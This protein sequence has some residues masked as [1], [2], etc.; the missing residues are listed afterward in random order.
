MC[1][2]RETVDVTEVRAGIVVGPGSAAFEVI[3]DLVYHLPLMVTPR[4]VRSLTQPIALD[5]LIE[6]LVR[7]PGHGA[8]GGVTCTTWEVPRSCATRTS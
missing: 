7:L 8:T 3:R 2:A 5:D 4:W 6:Y 1:C